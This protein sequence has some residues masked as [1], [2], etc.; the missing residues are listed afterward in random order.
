MEY[1]YG[2]AMNEF[3]KVLIS[4]MAVIQEGPEQFRTIHDGTH[5]TLLNYDIKVPDQE[6][7]CRVRCLKQEAPDRG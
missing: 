1:T 6:Q 3:V 5:K 2:Q 4:S 7:T